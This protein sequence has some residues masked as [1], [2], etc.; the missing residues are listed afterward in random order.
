MNPVRW[1]FWVIGDLILKNGRRKGYIVGMMLNLQSV[2]TVCDIHNWTF[3]VFRCGPD[4]WTCKRFL[5]YLILRDCF[6]VLYLHL[7][8]FFL[9][10]FKQVEILPSTYPRICIVW[11]CISSALIFGMHLV[12]SYFL[13]IDIGVRMAS[14][15]TSVKEKDIHFGIPSSR[16]LLKAI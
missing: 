8:L 16:S 15:K 7:L 10:I 4:A 11:P 5:P 6:P 1:F 3:F 13:G 12:R 14:R 2:S 9:N